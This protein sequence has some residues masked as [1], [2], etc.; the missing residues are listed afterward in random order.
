[1]PSTLPAA[2]LA[3][4]GRYDEAAGCFILTAEPPRKWWNLHCTAINHTGTE[5]YAEVAHINDGPTWVRDADGTTVQL[6]GYDHKYHYV[7][8]DQTNT[9][10]CPAGNPA[11]TPVTD[12]TIRFHREKTVM[13]STCSGLRATQRV[14]VPQKTPVECTTITVENLTD[15]PRHVSVFSYAMFQLTGC[16][17]EGRGF[18]KENIC[19]AHRDLQ[20]V[21][22]INRL[23]TLPTQRAKAF[24]LTLGDYFNANTYRDHFTRA[25]YAVGTPKIL[26]GWD[27][28]GRPGYGPDCAG[29][30]QV[31]LT[32]PPHGTARVDFVLGQTGDL[33][34]ALAFK[35]TLTPALLDQ[36]C[37]EAAAIEACRA[38]SFTIRL[39]HELYDGLYNVFIKKQLYNYLI[40]KSGFRDNLQTDIALAIADY[41]AAEA[42]LLR[43]LASQYPAGHFPHGFRPLNRLQYSDKPAWFLQ[44]LPALIQESGNFDLLKVQVPYLESTESGTV[45]DHALRA[46]RFLARDLGKNGLCDQHHAD[47]NDG[48][49]ATKEAGARESVFVTMQL[50][51]GLREM[52][53]LARRIGDTAVQKE[54]ADLYDVFKKRIN[55]VCWDGEWFTRTHC[56]D[57]YIIGSKNCT[58]GKI[59][60]NTQSWAVLSGVADPE[61]AHAVM[62]QVD[63]QLEADIGYRICV[64]AYAEYDPRVGAMSKS[65][66]GANENGGCYNHAGGFKG[67]ADC[68]LGRSEQA[69]R[70]FTKITP[71][72]P[73][74]PLARSGAEPFSYVNSYSSVPQIYGKSGYAWRTGTAGWMTQLLIEYILGAR[75]SY[76]GLIIDPCLPAALPEA[77]LT[78]RFRGATYQIHLVNRPGGGKGPK[79]I[80][81]DGQP[82][83]GQVLPLATSGEYQVVVRL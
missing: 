8:D 43:A 3:N 46:M 72:S 18:W 2:D 12:R 51:Y 5:M 77:R 67:V 83:S 70:T 65:M 74:N 25:E 17:K 78:R 76:D 31:K 79:S 53:E 48:L 32:I 69:W 34:E 29:I 22:C 63:E 1:M 30:V 26:D 54:A 40:N 24:L 35:A 38:S 81:L 28:D 75:R 7:R 61:R 49:E 52:A 56:G 19:E 60:V 14:F 15:R 58:Y 80:T 36:W 4:Y 47:W 11:P 41:P 64:P 10:F 71:G 6:V 68:L 20:G 82:V 23:P 66:P 42:N 9:V 62:R 16:D 73:E 50:A 57:G 21:L 59:F 39:G 33:A 44:V 37:D 13:Q 45:W 55:E 27:T